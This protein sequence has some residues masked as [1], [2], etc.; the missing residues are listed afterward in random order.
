MSSISVIIPCYNEAESIERTIVRVVD[1]STHEFLQRIIVV[2][3][4]SSDGTVQILETLTQKYSKLVSFVCLDRP[5]RGRQLITGANMASSAILLFLHAD[6]LLPQKWDRA[7]VQSFAARK[8]QHYLIG[9]FQLSLPPPLTTSLFV[10]VWSANLRAKVAHLPYGDQAYFVRR[11]EYENVGGFA[12]IPLMED[13]DLLQRYKSY[14][15]RQSRLAHTSRYSF[16][17]SIF[18]NPVQLLHLLQITT[19]VFVL[20]LAVVT[21]PRR[22]KRKGVWWNTICNQFFMLAW[23]AG[24]S[25]TTI[26]NWYYGKSI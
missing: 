26:Y 7:I 4:G 25:P 17:C 15:S 1:A 5:S 21:S 9:C 12:D 2:D 18:S 24:A 8:D 13:V 10:M 14:A 23:L 6:T 3:G 16:L 22:W 19:C 11:Q 20:P